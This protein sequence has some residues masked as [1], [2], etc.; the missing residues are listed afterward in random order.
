MIFAQGGMA[1]KS[2]SK[3]LNSLLTSKLMLISFQEEG[4]DKESSKL[5]FRI[6]HLLNEKN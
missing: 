1:D 2:Q 4:G 5:F 3:D 6:A